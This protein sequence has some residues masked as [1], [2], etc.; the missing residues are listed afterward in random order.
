MFQPLAVAYAWGYLAGVMCGSGLG[1]PHQGVAVW[2][3]CAQRRISEFKKWVQS[4]PERVIVAVGHS[5]Y[6]K[7]FMRGL[8]GDAG[9]MRN[10][11]LMTVRL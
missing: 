6:W 11:E 2:A 7:E 3:A 5:C 4:R 10:C 1:L 8:M 9:Y